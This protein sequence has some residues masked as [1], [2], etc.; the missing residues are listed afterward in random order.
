MTSIANESESVSVPAAIANAIEQRPLFRGTMHLAMAIAA[1]FLLV[2]LL[3]IADSPREYV[4]GAVYAS[5][6]I[7][8]YLTSATYHTVPWRSPWKS[9]MQ[10]IDHSMIFALIAGTYTPFCLLVVGDAWGISLLAVVWTFAGLGMLLKIAWPHAPRWFGVALYLALGW[11]GIV[12]AWPVITNLGVGATLTLLFGGVLYSVGAICYAKR[13][14]DPSP[15]FFG[16]HEVFH[17]LVI[18]GSVTH[19]ALVAAYVFHL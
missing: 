14:P 5:T 19:F 2:L 9:V 13:W 16:Y 11:V 17:T 3:L 10:R 15:R 8:L 4:G 12:A 18:A 7:A 6:L 1:P